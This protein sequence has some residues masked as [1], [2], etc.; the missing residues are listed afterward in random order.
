V[1]TELAMK[2]GGAFGFLG[3]LSAENNDWH[4][5]G[6]DVKLNAP[7]RAIFWFKRHKESMTYYVL[8]ADLSVKEVSAEKAPKVPLL[9]GSPKQ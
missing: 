4:Y 2:T 1:A 8:Y 9:E 3:A 7:D 6:K 5:A